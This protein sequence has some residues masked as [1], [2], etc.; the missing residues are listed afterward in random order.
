MALTR[1]APSKNGKQHDGDGPEKSRPAAQLWR[2]LDSPAA[3]YYL[4]LGSTIALTLLGLVMVLSASSV[5]AYDG[6][7]GSSFSVFLRQA[8]FAAAGIPLM[9]IASRVP[10]WFWKKIA[11]GLLIVGLL[12]Q[13]LPFTPLGAESH[14]N[15]SWIRIG[16]FQAQPAEAGKL[17]LVLWLGV[18]LAAKQKLLG[19]WKHVAIPIVPV[20]GLMLMFVLL[21]DDLGTGLIFMILVLGAL[22]VAGVPLRMFGVAG[23]GLALVAV[24]LAISSPNRMA[25]ISSLFGG[26]SATSDYSGQDWQSTHG[27]WALA[28]GGWWGVGLGASREK[29][30]WLP[31]AHNDF[32]YAIIGE[33]LGLPGTLGV[34]VLFMILG[35]ALLRVV[36][37]STDL[38]VKVTT[39]AVFAWII[40]QAVINIGVVLSLF[41]VIGVPLP[42]VSYGGSALLTTL[43]ALGI[44]LSFARAEAG[45]SAAMAQQAHQ[46]RRS[47]AVLGR[48]RAQREGKRR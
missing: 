44:V 20:V 11:W 35:L 43:A 1:P 42:L 18:V 27:M 9:F 16:S 17:A 4:I 33:E 31:E 22:F 13:L 6:G 19:Q 36:R 30:Q 21:G 32:I 34:L 47:L 12:V 23:V 25:R 26:N 10:L 48:R 37:R 24:L 15:K 7:K 46:V 39:G 5:E 38:M 14:G 29:W 3:S 28:S 45:A 2:L 41:P 8:A 40:A